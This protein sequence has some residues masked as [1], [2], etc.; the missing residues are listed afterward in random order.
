MLKELR[1][2]RTGLL[3]IPLA[4]AC[5][6]ILRLLSFKADMPLA[7]GGTLDD[8]LTFLGYLP[9]AVLVVIVPALLGAGAVASE[10]QLGVIGW[11]LGLPASR[12]LQWRLKLAVGVLL[13]LSSGLLGAALNWPLPIMKLEPGMLSTLLPWLMLWSLLALTAGLFGSRH[14][15]GSFQALGLAL[16]FGV[17]LWF[18]WGLWQF[19]SSIAATL[20]PFELAT[21]LRLGDSRA[22]GLVE[23]AIGLVLWAA[24][25]A[26]PQPGEWISGRKP[27]RSLTAAVAIASIAL[28]VQLLL[29][30]WTGHQLEREI[31]AKDAEIEFLGGTSSLDWLACELG[32]TGRPPGVDQLPKVLDL[33]T[34]IVLSN[35]RPHDDYNYYGPLRQ[36]ESRFINLTVWV[37]GVLMRKLD[38]WY[39][40]HNRRG[41]LYSS[42]ADK[43]PIDGVVT[44]RATAMR[45][46]AFSIAPLWLQDKRRAQLD[47]RVRQNV[48]IEAVRTGRQLER[49]K[50]RDPERFRRAIQHLRRDKIQEVEVKA[51]RRAESSRAEA[52][53]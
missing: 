46:R 20:W 39:W 43:N 49:L 48:I 18:V 52:E 42:Y 11:Q 47:R 10:R 14:A 27:A 37:D 32:L 2:Q 53:P 24:V 19:T 50:A 44:Q 9:P 1:L 41:L 36:P 23:V 5:W 17:G 30:T 28:A 6:I 31:V 33:H 16:A 26:T 21:L 51:Q 15:R 34:Y 7:G 38:R 29:F 3:L 4:V 13:A 35:A 8:L 22:G 12:R 25:W 45:W 40:L